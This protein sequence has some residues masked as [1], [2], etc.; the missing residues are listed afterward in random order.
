MK[1]ECP[2]NY[3]F[4]IKNICV[5]EC[6]A[7]H[8][9]FVT[10]VK[11][12]LTNCQDDYELL[13]KD[14][15]ECVNKCPSEYPFFIKKLKECVSSCP[16]K[17][18]LYTKELNLCD[19]KCNEDY[20]L[21]DK[22]AKQCLSTCRNHLKGSKEYICTLDIA[23]VSEPIINNNSVQYNTSLNVKTFQ[24]SINQ[25]I[26]ILINQLSSEDEN[27]IQK[28]IIKSEEFTFS[29]YPNAAFTNDIDLIDKQQI[30]L[31]ECENILRKS[32]NISNDEILL[33]GQLDYLPNSSK[34]YSVYDIRGKKLELNLCKDTSIKL[35]SFI[36]SYL[37]DKEIEKITTFYKQYGINVLNETEEIFINHCTPYSINEKDTTVYDRRDKVLQQISICD[38]GCQLTILNFTTNIVECECK[39]NNNEVT[40]SIKRNKILNDEKN[41]KNRIIYIYSD[42]TI[43]LLTFKLR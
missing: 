39:Q 4:I 9:Y 7:L 42:V 21:L 2:S 43:L 1:N 32:Y 25:T 16:N 18:P 5:K 40:T 12:C 27:T 8:P 15:N 35:S 10:S 19:Y 3:S 17:Y 30:N 37:E 24:S 11:E 36:S 6:P 14:T 31:N 33:I 29:F 28:T 13:I 23:N 26:D 41:T 20:P 34:E 22:Q 38:D